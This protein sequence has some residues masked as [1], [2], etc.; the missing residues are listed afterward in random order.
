MAGRRVATSRSH[1]RPRHEPAA[2]FCDGFAGIWI[3]Y[4]LL[5]QGPLVAESRNLTSA[6]V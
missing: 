2:L 1:S 4:P 3:L 6:A 5:G